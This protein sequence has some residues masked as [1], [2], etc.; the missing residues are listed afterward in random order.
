MGDKEHL[1]LL[2]FYMSSAFYIVPALDTM[3]HIDSMHK[4]LLYQDLP[5]FR[6]KRYT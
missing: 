3:L 2:D 5:I 4:N 6:F 1:H